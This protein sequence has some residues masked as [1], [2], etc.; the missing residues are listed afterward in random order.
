MGKDKGDLKEEAGKQKLIQGHIEPR[1]CCHKCVKVLLKWSNMMLLLLG[2]GITA[3]GAYL[4]I[5]KKG[6]VTSLSGVVLG[7]GIVNI[8]FPGGIILIGHKYRGCLHFNIF[9]QGMLFLAE[10][11][12]AIVFL[13]QKTREDIMKKAPKDERE[14]VEN[15]LKATA[16]V[17]FAIAVVQLIALATAYARSQ[18]LIENWELDSDDVDETGR[19]LM[20]EEKKQRDEER[21]RARV[22]KAKSRHYE[23]NKEFYERYGRAPKV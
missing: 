21:E 18:G 23:K 3:Y 6:S 9:V 19:A 22:E 5:K 1:G 13:T 17:L 8:V 4:A 12:A 15:H 10:I 20:K 14:R 2:L 16:Y 11:T 7:V